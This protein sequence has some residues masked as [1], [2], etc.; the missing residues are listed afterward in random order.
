MSAKREK[1]MGEKQFRKH[2]A[3]G[4]QAGETPALPANH[5]SGFED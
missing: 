4:A 5:L 2:R 3:Y 1:W